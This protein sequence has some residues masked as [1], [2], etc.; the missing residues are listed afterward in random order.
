MHTEDITLLVHSDHKPT[1]VMQLK[2]VSSVILQGS[3][4]VFSVVVQKHFFHCTR[5]ET[6]SANSA[7][8]SVK[9][10]G[11]NWEEGQVIGA[12][13]MEG[14]EELFLGRTTGS[15]RLAK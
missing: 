1:D 5:F 8:R 15:A 3:R 2:K 4:R 7:Y 14:K 13:M 10:H 6:S 12:K 9:K 11:L